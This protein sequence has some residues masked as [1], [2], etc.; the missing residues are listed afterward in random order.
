VTTGGAARANPHISAA[1]KARVETLY[2]GTAGKAGAGRRIA[3]A[4]STLVLPEPFIPTSTVSYSSKS[5]RS[6]PNPRKLLNSR[7]FRIMP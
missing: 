1:Y 2:A 6:S 5:I 3:A 4:S 7:H